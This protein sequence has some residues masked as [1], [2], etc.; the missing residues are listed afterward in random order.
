MGIREEFEGVS[1]CARRVA[2]RM[3]FCYVSSSSGYVSI[4]FIPD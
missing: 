2:P 1:A 4:G 3:E